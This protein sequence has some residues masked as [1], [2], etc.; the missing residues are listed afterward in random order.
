MLAPAADNHH[1]GIKMARRSPKQLS[2]PAPRRWGGRRV[3][4]GRKRTQPRPGPRHVARPIHDG[5]H[6]VHVTLR[7][8][9]GIPSLRSETLFTTLRRALSLASGRR[10]RVVQFSVQTNHLHLIVEADSR[11]ALVRG[12]Q[13][14]AIRCA[15]AVNRTA[16]R[17][18]PV[19][20]GRY[21][22]RALTTPREVRRGLAYVLLNFRKHLRAPPGV[23]P[24]SSGPWF[25]GWNGSTERPPSPAPTVQPSTWLAAVGWRR[26]GGLLDWHERPS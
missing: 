18:G 8:A 6:P 14:L 4:A 11:R 23:D 3:G 10:F 17:T 15:L 25:D 12:L 19:W 5:C 22:A 21:H 13:G 16:Q 1:C 9:A 24:R 2:L 20:S 26:A 7:S